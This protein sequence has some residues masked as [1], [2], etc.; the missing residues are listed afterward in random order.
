MKKNMLLIIGSIIMILLITTAIPVSSELEENGILGRTHI[1]A[2][3]YNFH[4]CEDDRG[5]YG[6]VI[7]GFKGL[8]P[9][10]NEDIYIPE[11]TIRFV[12]MSKLTLNC[13]YEE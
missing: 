6:H 7:I 1:R 3:G 13:I 11:D 4:I 10:I 8:K 2:I 12:V 5:I 9:V